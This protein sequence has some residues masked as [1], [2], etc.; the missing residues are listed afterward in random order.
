MEKEFEAITKKTEDLWNAV[1]GKYGDHVYTLGVNGLGEAV[2]C[3]GYAM[4]LATGNRA[5]QEKLANLLKA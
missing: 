2:L 5:I 3:E 4:E 1:N